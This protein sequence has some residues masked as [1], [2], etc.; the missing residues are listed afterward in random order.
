MLQPA[1]QPPSAAFSG[2]LFRVSWP[3]FSSSPG[4]ACQQLLG[5]LATWP[6]LM[7]ITAMSGPRAKGMSMLEHLREGSAPTHTLE[8]SNKPERKRLKGLAVTEHKSLSAANEPHGPVQD[9]TGVGAKGNQNPTLLLRGCPGATV[10]HGPQHGLRCRVEQGP[11]GSCI[12]H[13]PGACGMS[14]RLGPG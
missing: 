5:T 11:A 10:Q 14:R 8:T 1:S 12:G 2:L 6:A 13:F 9:S 7:A 4:C 3:L